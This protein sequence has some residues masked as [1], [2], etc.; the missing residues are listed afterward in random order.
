MI[1]RFT[2]LLLAAPALALAHPGHSAFA[3]ADGVPHAGHEWE[4]LCVAGLIATTLW[5]VLR[6][7]FKRRN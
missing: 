6:V 2:F 3:P 1:R 4:Y 7:F 5:L